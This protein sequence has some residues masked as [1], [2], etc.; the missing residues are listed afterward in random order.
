MKVCVEDFFNSLA[1]ISKKV[2]IICND[3][4]GC[5]GNADF[6]IFNGHNG[7][8]DDYSEIRNS[9]DNIQRDAAVIACVSKEYFLEYFRCSYSYPLVTTTSLL[10]PE[11]YVAEGIIN[12]WALMKTDEEIRISAGNAMA[13]AH[14]KN[15]YLFLKISKAHK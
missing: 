14:K 11:A 9:K 10:P 4:I 12:S 13:K 7:L 1:G 8:A 2:I 15:F 3:T 5:A 6:L